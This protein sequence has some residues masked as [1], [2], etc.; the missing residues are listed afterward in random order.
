MGTLSF[1]SLNGRMRLAGLF[2]SGDHYLLQTGIESDRAGNKQHF[3]AHI[4][5]H[6]G[7]AF[8]T[9]VFS[10]RGSGST[11]A[12]SGPAKHCRV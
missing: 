8:D 5:R 10:R 1:T 7:C 4:I 9:C 2:F 3:A 12:T 11:Q 6:K